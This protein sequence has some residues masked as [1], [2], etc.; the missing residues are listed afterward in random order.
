[1]RKQPSSDGENR[2]TWLILVG[3]GDLQHLRFL[4]F[5]LFLAIYVVTVGGNALIVLAVASS[6]TL[7][8]P[9]YFFLCHFS[10]LEIGYTSN[11]VPQLLQS[12]LEGKEAISLLSCLLQFYVF[13]SLAAAECL[14]LSA[15]SY[16]RYLAICRPL[17]YPA[18]M[19]TWSCGC[20]A[21]GAWF[22]GFSFSAF[23]LALAAPLPLCPGSREIDHYFC[24]FAPVVG[25]FCGDVGVMWGAGVSISGFLTL[26]PFLFI[27]TSYAFILRTVLRIPSGGG[28]QKAFS[29]CSSHLSVVGVFYGTLVVVYVAPTDHMAPLLRK[30]FS[31]LYTV[32][33]PMANPIIYSLKNQEVK[34][35]LHRLWGQ[36]LPGQ[37]L[38]SSWIPA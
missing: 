17:H 20:L 33:T 3:F 1:M 34:R 37:L 14:L 24:D 38:T 9:M 26:A 29:T 22:S 18:L 11:I 27:V 28:R 8:T 31:V 32:F 6:R 25:L 36:L 19:S 13:A 21:A 4:P 12:L 35:A 15:M 5:T 30:A 2:T 7:H 23:T 10:V 16:D